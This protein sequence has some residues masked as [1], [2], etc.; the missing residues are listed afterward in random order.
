LIEPEDHAVDRDADDFINNFAADEYLDELHD[1]Y[2]L[3]EVP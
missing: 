1:F 3:T 2:K